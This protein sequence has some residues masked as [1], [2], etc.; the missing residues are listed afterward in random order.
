MMKLVNLFFNQHE[1][2]DIDWSDY[3]NA[4]LFIEN[5]VGEPKSSDSKSVEY[6]VNGEASVQERKRF[7]GTF[8]EQMEL[9]EFPFDLQVMVKFMITIFT[10]HVMH[11]VTSVTYGV[12][13]GG[14][15]VGSCR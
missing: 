6:N 8:L 2:A 14:L 4:K 9:W 10:V 3:W 11:C 1:P 13:S 5:A 12:H 15:W 7:K